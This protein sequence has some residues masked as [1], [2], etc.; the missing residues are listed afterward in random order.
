MQKLTKEPLW[1]E[2]YRPQTLADVI[3]T[4]K[5]RE[6]LTGYVSSGV[7]PN[8]LLH[9]PPGV[10]KTSV[11]LALLKDLDADVL[12][13]NGSSERNIDTLRTT[14]ADFARYKSIYGNRKVVL[15]DEAE[16]LN[17][18]STQPAMRSFMEQHSRNC[19]FVLTCNDLSLIHDAIQSRC[20]SIGFVVS[21]TD[22]PEMAKAICQRLFAILEHEEVAYDKK[23]VAR[24]V[25]RMFPDIRRMINVLQGYAQARKKVDTGILGVLDEHNI[26]PLYEIMKAKSFDGMRQWVA[27]N[28]PS[29]TLV[30]L[31]KALWETLPLHVHE[32]DIT[33]FLYLLGESH[34]VQAH[35]VDPEIEAAHL[36][37]QI[38][39]ECRFL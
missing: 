30:G 29:L 9:G 34:R 22:Y 24:L 39:H 8:L 38:M 5:M 32:D 14:V 23:V 21:D 6:T 19:G 12:M 26:G 16:Y 33:P 7:L 15:I 13:I 35:V 18:Q 36:L 10:G 37:N 11:A 20:T 28:I 31:H 3:L 25:K 17:P 2:A 4:S 27:D 1:V